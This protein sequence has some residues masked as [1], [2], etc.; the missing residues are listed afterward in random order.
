MTI[1]YVN[2]DSHC[3]GEGLLPTDKTFAQLVAEYF[4]LKLINESQGGCSN[5]RI[6]RTSNNWL[7]KNSSNVA[8]CLIGITTWEREEWYYDN[9]FWNINSSG[10]GAL[11]YDLKERYTNWVIN[12]SHTALLSKGIIWEKKMWD[13]HMQLI[14]SGTPHVFFNLFYPFISPNHN[15][16]GINFIGPYENNLSY[17][18]YLKDN[19]QVAD[20]HYHYNASGHKLWAKFLINYIE[21]NN[22][23]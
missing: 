18:H 23:L 17:Y 15:D 13:F 20:S 10:P 11:P 2:G 3:E 16:W 4:N 8:L 9:K 7:D 5:D 22:L 19:R 21:E 1:L 14:N 6:L 12:N